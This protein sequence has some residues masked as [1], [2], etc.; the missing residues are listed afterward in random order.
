MA[1]AQEDNAWWNQKSLANLDLSSNTL[2]NIEK[3]I[4]LLQDLTVLNVLISSSLTY[5][6]NT[7]FYNQIIL[8]SNDFQLHDNAL[9]S[10]PPAIGTLQKL[11]KLNISHN[12]LTELPTEFFQL[13]DLRQLNLSHN[14]FVE[15]NAGVSDMVMLEVLVS[16]SSV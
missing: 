5:L 6:N 3:D 8:N 13:R 14:S 4:G 7:F 12:K 1:D 16:S 9:T 15:I 10:I 2:T 11:T